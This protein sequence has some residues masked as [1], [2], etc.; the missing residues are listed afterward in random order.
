MR[1]RRLTAG[2]LCPRGSTTSSAIDGTCAGLRSPHSV[3][4]LRCWCWSSVRR[5]GLWCSWWA[6]LVRSSSTRSPGSLAPSSCTVCRWPGLQAALRVGRLDLSAS[7]L[8]GLASPRCPFSSTSSSGAGSE[9][10]ARR[11][12]TSCQADEVIYFCT[13]VAQRSPRSAVVGLITPVGDTSR[14]TLAA[15]SGGKMLY[16]AVGVA[17]ILSA[18]LMWT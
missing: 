17:V 1:A 12:C 18:V 13:L 10:T 6:G 9:C 11:R 7:A 2:C 15:K 5:C 3:Y 14:A 4:L 16:I 8:L